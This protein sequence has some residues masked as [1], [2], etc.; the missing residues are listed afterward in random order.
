[1]E[2]GRK[3]AVVA[4]NL[5]HVSVRATDI[6]QSVRF[7]EEVFGLKRIP[8]PNFGYP[9]QW[10]RV[11][12]LQLHIFERP[13]NAPPYQHFALSVDDFEAVFRAARERGVL[14][15]TAFGHHIYELPGGQVQMYLKDPGGNLVE[16][17]W[18]DVSTLSEEVR[19]QMKVMANL[20]PQSPE[21]M[22]A[23]L[24]LTGA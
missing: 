12:P 3:R 1:V 20:N 9:V 8:T 18:P 23:R 22:K 21:N 4:T 14:D 7:Y 5:N 11:G 19:A 13:G 17:D 24:F 2:H 6:E 10:L 16:V 15:E